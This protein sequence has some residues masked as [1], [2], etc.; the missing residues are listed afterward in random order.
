MSFPLF[1]YTLVVLLTSGLTSA[2]C[3]SIFLLSRRNTYLFAA[4]CFFTYFFD[5]ALVLRS[6][7]VMGHKPRTIYSITSPV[8]S[9][10]LA[11]ILTGCMWLVC[12][13][14]IEVDLRWAVVPVVSVL[15]LSTAA[16]L[17]I[18]EQKYAEFCFFTVRALALIALLVF[19]AVRYFRESGRVQRFRLKRHRLLYVLTALLAV[20]TIVWNVVF[21]LILPGHSGVA[22]ERPFLPERNFVENLLYLTWMVFILGSGARILHAHFEEPPE[23]SVGP[24]EVF[25]LSA[26]RVFGASSNLTEREVEVFTHILAGRTN[27]EIANELFLSESTVKVHVHNI[28]KKTTTADRKELTQAFWHTV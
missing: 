25:L 2:I 9:M 27:R 26:V 4:L 14:F 13:A 28:L 17:L 7:F 10:I 11:A 23:K 18:E 24:D 8:E 1:Y 5:V 19:L 3:V 20:G 6:S 15:V 16:L 12:L 22:N 21:I